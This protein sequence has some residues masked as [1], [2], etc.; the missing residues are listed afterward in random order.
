VS[1]DCEFKER[2]KGRGRERTLCACETLKIRRA[3]SQE[4]LSGSAGDPKK[5]REK[6]EEQASEGK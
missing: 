1:I 3:L 6:E 5:R 4:V 2:E